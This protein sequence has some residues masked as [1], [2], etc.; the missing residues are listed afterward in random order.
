ME[1]NA[2]VRY[3]PIYIQTINCLL[4]VTLIV[5]FLFLLQFKTIH[6]YY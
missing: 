2:P 6:K 1:H 3:A 5:F 4:D